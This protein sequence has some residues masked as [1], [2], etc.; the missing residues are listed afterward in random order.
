MTKAAAIASARKANGRY[1]PLLKLP[2]GTTRVVEQS[3]DRLNRNTKHG[4][5]KGDRYAVGNTYEFRA[6]AIAAAAA[7][8]NR[9]LEDAQT[10]M[11]EYAGLGRNTTYL[12]SEVI[13][14]GGT[15]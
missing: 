13:L 8:I 5:I 4:Y 12:E 1:K 7:Y 3:P 14:W 9:C 2:N 15:V 11:E 6:D 10:R